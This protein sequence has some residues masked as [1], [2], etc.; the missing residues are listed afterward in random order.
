MV[1]HERQLVWLAALPPQQE[2]PDSTVDRHSW[3]K[4][5]QLEE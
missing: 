5:K 1:S 4:V 3:R 2:L